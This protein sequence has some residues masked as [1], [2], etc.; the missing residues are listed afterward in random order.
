MGIK[1]KNFIIEDYGNK[2]SLFKVL[3]NN[4]IKFIGDFKII[5][6]AKYYIKN[7]KAKYQES[8]WN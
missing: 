3:K 8:L 7:N 2:I 1:I 5:I 4:K 6:E